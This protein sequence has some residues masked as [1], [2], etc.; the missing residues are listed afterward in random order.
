MS[1]NMSMEIKK[2]TIM[3]VRTSD[4]CEKYSL[5]LDFCTIPE[6][7]N[8]RLNILTLRDLSTAVG[9]VK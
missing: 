2:K 1:S 6:S 7:V 9:Y 5:R 8:K 4:I 3:V